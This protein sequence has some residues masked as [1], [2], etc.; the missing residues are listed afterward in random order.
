MLPPEQPVAALF[1]SLLLALLLFVTVGKPSMA[2]GLSTCDSLEISV[3]YQGPGCCWTFD[4]NNGLGINAV[5]GISATILSPS[6][7]TIASV[8]GPWAPV[9]S[10]R[11]ITWTAPVGGIPPGVTRGLAVCFNSPT[12]PVRVLF[13]WRNA[14]GGII[15]RD[16]LTLDCQV[17]NCLNVEKEGIV[18]CITDLGT[19]QPAYRFRFALQNLASW[20][21][22]SV[23][24]SGPAGVSIAPKTLTLG[25]LAPGS[26]LAAQSVKI[27]GAQPGPMLLTLRICDSSGLYCC[28]DTIVLDL[29]KCERSCFDLARVNATCITLPNG[30]PGYNLAFSVKNLGAS[31]AKYITILTPGGTIAPSNLTLPSSLDPGLTSGTQNVTLENVRPGAM[32]LMLTLCDSLRKECCTDSIKVDLPDCTTGCFDVNP[33][34]NIQC[35]WSANGPQFVWCFSIK[36][37]A[38]WNAQYLTLSPMSPGVKIS[39]ATTVFSPSV[40][41]GGGAPNACIT[42]GGPDAV[43][44]QPLSFIASLCDAS[45]SR[46]CLDTISIVLPTCPKPKEC[47]ED[48]TKSFF[49]VVNSTSAS[50]AAS[51]KGDFSASGPGM[52]GLRSVSATLESATID[53]KPA[54][55]YMRS[56]TISNPFSS[57]LPDPYPHTVTWPSFPSGVNMS[58]PT[59]FYL[60]LRFPPVASLLEADTLSYCIRYRFT[61]INCMTCDTVICYTSVRHRFLDLGFYPP[62]DVGNREKGS[63]RHIASAADPAISGA[64]YSRDSGSLRIVFP[65]SP[66]GNVTYVGLGVTP[67]GAGVVDAR[68]LEPGYELIVANGSAM[69]RFSAKPGAK[70]TLALRYDSLGARTSLEHAL[71]F[72]YTIEGDPADTLEEEVLVTLRKGGLEGGDELKPV[73]SSLKDVRTFALHLT[74]AN[75]S[76]EPIDRLVLGTKS[77]VKI[78]AVGPTPSDSE[79][80]LLLGREGGGQFAGV[81]LRGSRST[82]AAGEGFGPLYVTLAG[83]ENNGAMVHFSTINANGEVISEGDLSLSTPLSGV[84]EGDR[85]ESGGVLMQ[86]YPN[87]A[88]ESATIWFNLPH[89]GRNVTLLLTDGTGREVMRL[90]DGE[91]LTAGEHAVYVNT[92]SLA[93][94][95]YY[96]VLSG[97]GGRVARSL[98]VLK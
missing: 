1:R 27:G 95:T 50:G 54:Y 53:G 77:P 22:S 87:P 9:A 46:C 56:G 17:E 20:N 4:L 72:Y 37:R 85:E 16:T 83:T 44:G 8:G 64:L 90:I 45:R 82:V 80:V 41:P 66:A 63:D 88:R 81:D 76:K 52:I 89:A 6:G 5:S 14:Q 94:G 2:Q 11:D 36:N 79:A 57:V 43:P 92:A 98:K 86:N 67:Q 93:S 68:A 39:A 49:K 47:C 48:F 96:T 34:E 26:T 33:G 19:G 91:T 3:N 74:N 42:I 23:T 65:P 21:A 30:K 25:S 12:S 40:M 75:A 38:S 58:A 24:F 73:L 71:T 15:C 28:T 51:L 7:A 29:P 97:E 13:S 84:H 60:K 61:D 70:L 78:V 31:K 55:G 10:S 59:G 35:V 18:E 62:V 32:T 69:A